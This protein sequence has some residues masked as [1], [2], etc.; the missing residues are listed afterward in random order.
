ME[1]SS[2]DVSSSLDLSKDSHV[3]INISRITFTVLISSIIVKKVLFRS[4]LK[5]RGGNDNRN[6]IYSSPT[7]LISDAILFVYLCVAPWQKMRARVTRDGTICTRNST[8]GYFDGTN[9]VTGK[10][11]QLRSPT[12]IMAPDGI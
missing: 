9:P 7:E 12:P 6:G 2:Q 11:I 4:C 8:F 10:G 5:F 1:Y 3:V